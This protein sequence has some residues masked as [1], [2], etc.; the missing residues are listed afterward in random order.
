MEDI[1]AMV[2]DV[3]EKVNP[4]YV[5]YEMYQINQ[6][7]LIFIIYIFSI[8][9]ISNICSRRRSILTASRKT[10]TLIGQ[11]RW[12]SSL[13]WAVSLSSLA[14]LS[15]FSFNHHHNLYHLYHLYHH[16]HHCNS[17]SSG[18]RELWKQE[19]TT[20][21]FRPGFHLIQIQIQMHI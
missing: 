1:E 20:P 11:M 7:Y 19:A 8:S 12:S 18:W 17:W 21:Q 14:S 10:T 4:I 2:A 16:Y 3:D 13:S 15:L 9:N 5:I 6:I